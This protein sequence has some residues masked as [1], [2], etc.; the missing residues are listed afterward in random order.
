MLSIFSIFYNTICLFFTVFLLS[1]RF[2]PSS[3]FSIVSNKINILWGKEMLMPSCS[4]LFLLHISLTE[5][6]VNTN[7]SMFMSNKQIISVPVQPL[8]LNGNVMSFL[9]ASVS[10]LPLI[11]AELLLSG[12]VRSLPVKKGGCKRRVSLSSTN[13]IFK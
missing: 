11:Q 13:F 1:S 6:A 3:A 7:K 9:E 5:C 4:L 2:C 12:L 10:E 8:V